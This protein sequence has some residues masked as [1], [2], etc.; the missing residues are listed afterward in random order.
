MRAGAIIGLALIA[1]WLAAPAMAQVVD[2]GLVAPDAS[3]RPSARPMATPG[4]AQAGGLLTLD[5]VAFYEASLWYQ[6]V[7]DSLGRDGV[8]LAAENDRLEAD[9]AQ[10]ERDLTTRR[11]EMAPEDF[12]AAA[13]AFDDTVVRTRREQEAKAQRLSALADAERKAFFNAALPAFA[14]VM[15]D[16]N[17]VA[18]LDRQSVFV[19]AQAI[20]VT[21]ELV[22]VIND[23]IG[24]GTPQTLDPGMA[25]M[26]AAP[27]IP[28]PATAP[29]PAPADAQPAAPQ[30]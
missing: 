22:R 2:P 23:S 20:D 12:R 11:A 8:A 27:P 29:P 6:R 4:P 10:Q 19:S 7:Q 15:A 24:E 21:D 9:L 26:S 14:Q 17:A 5:P 16:H 30:P 25:G 1:G 13:A 3:P 28:A 18:I